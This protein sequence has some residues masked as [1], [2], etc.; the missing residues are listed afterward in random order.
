V[1]LGGAGV[2]QSKWVA[3]ELDVEL[4]EPSSPR[5]VVYTTGCVVAVEVAVV[6]APAVVRGVWIAWL[7]ATTPRADPTVS[8]VVIVQEI[9]ARRPRYIPAS[10]ENSLLSTFYRPQMRVA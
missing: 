9:T 4:L 6:A 3:V 10:F 7:T 2:Y 5:Y 8:I 1:A